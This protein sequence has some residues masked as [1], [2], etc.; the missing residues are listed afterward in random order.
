VVDLEPAHVRQGP[1]QAQR[2]GVVAR[3]QK[4][5]LRKASLACLQAQP[6]DAA[7]ADAVGGL[8]LVDQPAQGRQ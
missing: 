1:C 8:Q 2:P 5:D 3:A 6:I 4:N 7:V